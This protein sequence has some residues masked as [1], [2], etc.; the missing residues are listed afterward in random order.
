MLTANVVKSHNLW[1]KKPSAC[2]EHPSCVRILA[3]KT[4][5]GPR[6]QASDLTRLVHEYIPDIGAKSNYYPQLVIVRIC[7]Y[8]DG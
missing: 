5:P 3:H 1:I 4:Q 8:A 2:Y 7:D 6:L